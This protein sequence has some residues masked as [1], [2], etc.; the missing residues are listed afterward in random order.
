MTSL[1]VDVTDPE[2]VD[3]MVAKANEEL[4]GI[5]ILINNAGVITMDKV[6]DITPEDWDFVMDVNAKGVFLCMRA[7]GAGD[8]RAGR[9]QHRQRR[10]PGR[11][12]RLQTLRPLLR[13]E[14]GGD[15]PQQR[16]W[17]WKSRRRSASTASARASSTPR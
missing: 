2:Q 3:E 7:D 15:P 4:D 5:D 12:A 9:G 1:G 13:L 17:R 11:Q 10:L 14:G 6:V 16:A 8:A